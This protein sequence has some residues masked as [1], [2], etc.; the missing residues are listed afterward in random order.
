MT[1]SLQWFPF[2]VDR[3]LGSRKVRRMS[4]EQIGVYVLLLC[5]QWDTGPLPDSDDELAF[6]GKVEVDAVRTVLSLCF[7]QTE[8]GWINE[9]LEDVREEQER[10]SRTRSR[11]GKAGARARWGLGD[12]GS[13]MRSPM[14]S[15]SI[16]EEKK[17]EE[18]KKP[19]TS[20]NGITP[21][22]TAS[23]E[24]FWESAK[25]KVGKL[26]AE[27]AF[28][29]AM[30]RKDSDTLMERWAAFN[31]GID[32]DMKFIPNPATWLNQGRWLDED[33]APTPSGRPISE[34]VGMIPRPS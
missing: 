20:G 10:K 18:K 2:Y 29:T 32:G 33:S 13:R 23:F 15:H 11:A 21:S 3:F 25:K 24:L 8:D 34:Q 30:K 14:R 31:A 28:K 4:A 9:A 19:S 5:E 12:D 26:A 22:L 1:P 16:R 27:R 7:L 6:M 17:R